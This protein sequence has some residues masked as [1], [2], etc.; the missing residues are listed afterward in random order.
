QQNFA[1]E[2]VWR[3]TTTKND[4]KQGAVNWPRIHDV[5][6]MYH[7]STT[8][9]RTAKRFKQPFEPYEKEYL[10]T[11]YN[12]KDPDG[13]RY[14]LSDLTAPGQGTR[15][16]PQY[17]FLGVTRFWRYNKE[18]MM[19]LHKEGRIEFRPSGKVPRLKVYL[20]DA[21][22]IA[23]GDVWTDIRGM[24]NF[25]N[26]M[27]GYPTQKPVAL[28]ERILE[29]SSNPGDVVLDP[30]CGC[31]TTIDAAE[32]L[33]REWVGIDITQLAISLIKNRLSDTY[34]SRMKFISGGA[35]APA[36]EKG[37]HAPRVSG[38]APPPNPSGASAETT[39]LE[40]SPAP[41][42]TTR[43]SSAAREA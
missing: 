17:E 25:G 15:G 16:H 43:A 13:R 9:A 26:E 11:F 2:I 40:S 12:F 6:L 3:R 42:P 18:K 14:R 20:D 37:A 41:V 29:A 1:N 36:V 32:K 19:Q 30:F 22:G 21:P 39:A 31:G 23:L 5:V 34:G 7:R 38:S 33:R 35:H 8:E 24:I 27:L 4:Y 28:L 10:D